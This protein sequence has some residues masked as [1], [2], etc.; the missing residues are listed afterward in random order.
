MD[1]IKH[2]AGEYKDK[3]QVCKHCGFILTDDTNV[4]YHPLPLTGFKEDLSIWLGVENNYTIALPSPPILFSG[5]KV[6]DCTKVN[7]K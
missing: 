2:L 7:V 4:I 1:W 5:D 6:I 3:I